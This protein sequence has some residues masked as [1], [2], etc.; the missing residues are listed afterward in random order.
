MNAAPEAPR[1]GSIC[2]LAWR[3]NNKLIHTLQFAGPSGYMRWFRKASDCL[4]R[5]QPTAP[6]ER[7][8]QSVDTSQFWVYCSYVYWRR[9]VMRRLQAD[10]RFVFG[11]P[12]WSIIDHQELGPLPV[13]A[14]TRADAWCIRCCAVGSAMMCELLFAHSFFLKNDTK[15]IQKMRPYPPLGTLYALAYLRQEGYTLK[16]FDATFAEGLGEF[17][18]ILDQEQ[19]RFVVLYED[20]FNFLNKMC[21]SHARQAACCMSTMA[22][23]HGARVIAAGADVTDAPEAYF[24]NGVEYA[25]LG[26]A[27]HQLC[28]LIGMLSGRRQGCLES[29]SGLAM[30]DP[31]CPGGVR[32]NAP[33]VPER[34]PD[35][36]PL[37]AWDMVDMEK[38]RTAWVN[39]HGFFSINMVTTRGCPFHCN[40]C[41]KPI[42]G[43]RYA[44]R[45]PANVAEEMAYVK[46][47]IKPDHIWFADDIFGLQPKWV[48]EFAEEVG[49]RKA[50]TPFMIQSRVDLMTERAVESLA[51][52]GCVEVWMGVESGSQKILDAMEKGIKRS[53]VPIARERL[54]RTGIRACFFIQ[55]GYPG[56]TFDDIMATVQLVR[57]NVPDDIGVSVSYPLPGTRFYEMVKAELGEKVR[58]DDSNDLAVVFH[59][60]Y[61]TAFY[62]K[63]HKLLH[64]DLLLRQRLRNLQAAD[65]AVREEM[66]SVNREWMELK[67]SE[68]RHRSPNPTL[69]R[70]GYPDAT[71]PDLSKRW[72]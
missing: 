70:K 9:D 8:E 69:I 48:D 23:A 72:N 54:R 60:S 22:R 61:E 24:S 6:E 42:W 34:H 56:E 40:W 33:S 50:A 46:R 19:P 18:A 44:M 21:L 58:W 52:A 13:L 45:S 5:S 17:Q 49:S 16:L 35:V 62:R 2:T 51:R 67:Q 31:E 68:S 41:A 11:T 38:Y 29:I 20:Q 30:P 3:V 64:R 63:L 53:M 14:S 43:Q 4:S 26:E 25:L 66:E 1:L 57:E 47:T 36:F 28:E 71:A 10:G 27:D 39:A 12:G 15:Q 32:R 37:P 55:F 59:G 65:V 7:R